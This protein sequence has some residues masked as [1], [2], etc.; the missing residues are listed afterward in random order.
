MEKIDKYE[1]LGRKYKRD[2]VKLDS[3]EN[4]WVYQRIK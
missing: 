4:A 3:G 1:K 2:M